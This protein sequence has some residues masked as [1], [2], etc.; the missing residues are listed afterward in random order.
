MEG[1][2]LT[3]L[4][5]IKASNEAR[6]ETKRNVSE[7]ATKRK[8]CEERKKAIRKEVINSMK[9][10]DTVGLCMA[11][12]ESALLAMEIDQFAEYAKDIPGGTAIATAVM[13]N[14]AQQQN[15]AQL[16]DQIFVPTYGPP[17]P[18]EIQASVSSKSHNFS[19]KSDKNDLEERPMDMSEDESIDPSDPL[20]LK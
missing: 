1:V 6:K 19:G 13:Y 5:K 7:Q 16:T 8:L 3:A 2:Q 12:E 10:G 17:P 11:N 14:L 4:Q 15:V 18:A 9:T 20:G